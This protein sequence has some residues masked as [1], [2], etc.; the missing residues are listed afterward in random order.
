MN[1]DHDKLNKKEKK[2]TKKKS[3]HLYYSAVATENIF[4]LF[5]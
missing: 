4:L 5:K 2:L 3:S 1:H